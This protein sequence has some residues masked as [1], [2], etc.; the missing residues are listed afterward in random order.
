M[1]ARESMLLSR[2]IPCFAPSNSPVPSPPSP[3]LRFL[4]GRWEEEEEP[5][6]VKDFR[7][8]ECCLLLSRQVLGKAS[9]KTPPLVREARTCVGR[10]AVQSQHFQF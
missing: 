3:V 1:N 2:Q 7:V 4:G 9:S 8:S 6:D 5:S 10:R